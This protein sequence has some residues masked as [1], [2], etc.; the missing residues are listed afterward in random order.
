VKDHKEQR[1]YE[2]NQ[3]ST[4]RR[5]ALDYA[6]QALAKASVVKVKTE[7]TN[8]KQQVEKSKRWK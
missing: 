4:E 8:S 2:S 1:E 3:S 6:L 5:L 7:T